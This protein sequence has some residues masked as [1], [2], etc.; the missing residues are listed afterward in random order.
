MMPD[1]LPLHLLADDL[2]INARHQ[3][4]AALPPTL[5][6][7]SEL[8]WQRRYNQQRYH[9]ATNQTLNQEAT[10]LSNLFLDNNF[11]FQL[12]TTPTTSQ[13][14]SIAQTPSSSLLTATAQ[15]R[16]STNYSITPSKTLLFADQDGFG[17]TTSS[18]DDSIGTG[19]GKETAEDSVRLLDEPT[20]MQEHGD[21]LASR[22]L[23]G[24][25]WSNLLPEDRYH[26]DGDAASASPPSTNSFHQQEPKSRSRATTAD[27][28]KIQKVMLSSGPGSRSS[29]SQ[30]SSGESSSQVRHLCPHPECDKH[31]STSGHARRH[32]RI[33]GN[34]RPFTCPQPGC[35]ATFTR[36]DNLQQHRRNR[37][38]SD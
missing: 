33:H 6:H 30:S 17:N 29:T 34:N 31:F 27:G 11:T 15:N 36:N 18:L 37:H 16:T 22:T 24:D 20:T 14:F 3:H 2:G 25:M 1:Y 28:N 12:P 13:P 32:S 10:G 19:K 8:L 26:S 7:E 21:P 35:L 23:D 9:A 4:N 5:Y 38:S